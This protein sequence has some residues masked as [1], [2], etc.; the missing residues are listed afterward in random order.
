MQ[1]L[2]VHGLLALLEVQQVG[3]H[4]LVLLLELFHLVGKVKLLVGLGDVALEVLFGFLLL[5][6]DYGVLL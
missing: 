6:I 2:L 3:L 1:E 4:G 5:F